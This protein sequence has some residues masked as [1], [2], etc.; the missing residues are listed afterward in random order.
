[1]IEYAVLIAL[2]PLLSAILIFFFGRWLPMKGAWL[3]ILAVAASLVLS[4][5]LFM[6]FMDGSLV[7]PVWS[8]WTWF[9]AGI[10]RFEVGILLD[11]ASIVMLLMVSTVSLLVQIYSLSYMSDAPHFKRFYAY[12]SLFTFSMLGLVMANNYLQFFVGWELMGACSYFLISFEFEREAAGAAGNKAFLTTRLGDLGFYAGLLTIF[13][14]SGTFNFIQIQEHLR[15]G[16]ISSHMCYIIALLMFCGSVG[17]SAQFPLHV[18][19][20]DAMEG[21]TPVSALIHAATMVAAGV[22]LV[23]R[24]Y[25]F[26]VA[27]PDALQI[28]AWVGGITA[29]FAATMAIT[30]NDI[31]KVLAYST[32]SQLGYMIM[33]MGVLAYPAGLF[34]LT[35][36]AAF[37]AL[38]FLAAGSVIHAAHTN[39]MTKMGSLS[40]QLLLTTITFFCGTLSLIGFPLTSGYYSKEM[41]LNS[42]FTGGHFVLFGIGCFT[43]F[44]TAFYMT[45]AFGLTFLGTPRERDRF[46]HAHESPWSM[47]LPLLLLSIP[48]LGLGLVMTSSGLVDK[49]FG[50]PGL[51]ATV[52]SHKAGAIAVGSGLAGIVLGGILYPGQLPFVG[53]L[54]VRFSPLYRLLQRKYYIDELY[55][56]LFI[57]RTVDLAHVA[58]WF[59][60]YV[61]DRVFVDGFGKIVDQL[62]VVKRW[63][64]DHVRENVFSDALARRLQNSLAQNYLLVMTLGFVMFV[65]WRVF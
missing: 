61:I 6:R 65:L 22:F 2:L 7:T 52:E 4:I 33:A 26:F 11:E 59:D 27:A 49:F 12:L 16:Y 47:T 10:Y 35:T 20:P 24:A 39:D 46:A 3:G 1:M 30:E 53:R 36:H 18:W 64:N 40:K 13:Y 54:A 14:V 38:L 37:K 48:A 21:P 63:V 58:N 55:G 62:S 60:A 19:L 51:P 23:A 8:S 44:L 15:D 32:I 9:T 5:D 41:I 28:V 25:G 31:K 57:R 56:F 43:A 34:H 45:R 17:K 29:V 50:W 42:A